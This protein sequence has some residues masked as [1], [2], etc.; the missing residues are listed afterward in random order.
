MHLG[1]RPSSFRP[2]GRGMLSASP[3][4]THRLHLTWGPI[5]GSFLGG[6][7]GNGHQRTPVSQKQASTSLQGGSPVSGE[8]CGCG[9]RARTPGKLDGCPGDSRQKRTGEGWGR[10]RQVRRRTPGQLGRIY[11]TSQHGTCCWRRRGLGELKEEGNESGD[12]SG[13]L[14]L[15][16][17]NSA[18]RKLERRVE[19]LDV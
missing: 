4:G 12:G 9:L 17:C 8:E 7:E 1:R 6:R 13:R 11:L 15:F 16:P 10:G 2:S 19:T 5:P 14:K 18:L 3:D